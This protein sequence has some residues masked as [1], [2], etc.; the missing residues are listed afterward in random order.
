[1]DLKVVL[2]FLYV[3]F[4]KAGTFYFR[5]CK[6]GMKRIRFYFMIYFHIGLFGFAYIEKQY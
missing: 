6:N 5:N 2:S 3:T 1:M 4:K